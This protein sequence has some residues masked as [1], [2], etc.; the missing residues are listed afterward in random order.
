MLGCDSFDFMFVM[1]LVC[2]IWLSL[3]CAATGMGVSLL[4]P[5]LIPPQRAAEYL[6]S[7]TTVSGV[8]AV[9]DGLVLE[10]VDKVCAFPCELCS[11]VF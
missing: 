7:G 3:H 5:R 9:T 8:A 4:L 11:E 1:L 2:L 10:A 6:L